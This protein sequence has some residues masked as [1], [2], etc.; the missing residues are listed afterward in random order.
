MA[1]QRWTGT[2][3]AALAVLSLFACGGGGSVRDVAEATDESAS[4]ESELHAGGSLDDAISAAGV[5]LRPPRG[6]TVE[7][8]PSPGGFVVAEDAADLDADTPGAPRL[9]ASPV[10]AAAPTGEDL[11]GGVDRDPLVGS[12]EASETTIA[13]RA[14]ALVEWSTAHDGEA[15]TTR[16]ITVSLGNGRAY[17]FTFEAPEAGFAEA[18]PTLDLVLATVDF[19]VEAVPAAE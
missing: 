19:D 13:G 16:L 3:G 17:T 18:L 8:L 10:V 5:S 11:V 7:E 14:A 15:E 4:D 6:W 2:L 9:I 1:R 12:V